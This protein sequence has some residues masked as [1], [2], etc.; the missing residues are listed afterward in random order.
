MSLRM[1][2]P[3]AQR[4]VVAKKPAVKR[5]KKVAAV[6][7]RQLTTTTLPKQPKTR[8]MMNMNKQKQQQQQVPSFISESNFQMPQFAFPM[9][10]K[11]AFFS[12]Q[13]D[14]PSGAAPGQMFEEKT[15]FPITPAINLNIYKPGEDY[16][17]GF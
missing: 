10:N 14:T 15:G 16:F 11:K 5:T 9:L 13:A 6:P 4:K 2:Q 8:A 1:K 3:K 12:T 17:M 7:K